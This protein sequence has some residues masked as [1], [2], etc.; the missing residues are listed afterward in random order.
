[1]LGQIV[2]KTPDSIS[3]VHE[4]S[5][6][7]SELPVP[8]QILLGIQRLNVRL[9]TIENKMEQQNRKMTEF[10]EFVSTFKKFMRLKSSSAGTSNENDEENF[11]ELKQMK[12]IENEIELEQFEA[13][14]G[15]EAYVMKLTKYLRQKYELN[16]KQD[17]N[18]FFKTL[19]RSL[20]A[21]TALLPFS[22]KGIK[23]ASQKEADASQNKCFKIV[24]PNLVAL[25]DSV[26]LLADCEHKSEHIDRYFDTHLR[27][28]HKEI[29][30]ESQRIEKNVLARK[31]ASRTH[32]RHLN[33]NEDDDDEVIDEIEMEADEAKRAKTVQ[34][35][36]NVEHVQIVSNINE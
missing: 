30:R 18:A 12:R 8:E 10:G 4:E 9:D 6:D 16:A 13:K 23:R 15:E 32:K 20:I 14:L 33:D 17:A 36:E 24:F 35:G 31:V 28:K 5:I 7:V 29:Q 22:W 34:E 3:S 11:A 26:L 19:I 1:M 2:D 21:P 25:I 27:S